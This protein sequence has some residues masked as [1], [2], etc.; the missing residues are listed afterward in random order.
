VSIFHDKHKQME[1]GR[2]KARIESDNWE[3]GTA[4]AGKHDLLFQNIRIE[5]EKIKGTLKTQEGSDDVE[6]AEK[7]FFIYKRGDSF[8]I[9]TDFFIAHPEEMEIK[10]DKND[11]LV[12]DKKA[13]FEIKIFN[14]E[15]YN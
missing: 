12:F 6:A 9:K 13:K 1:I 15:T 5:N 10:F 14:K 11:L 4:G 8:I 7:H 2:F 3:T